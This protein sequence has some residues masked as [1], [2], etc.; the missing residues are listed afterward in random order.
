MTKIQDVNATI[1]TLDDSEIDFVAGGV[2]EGGCI[3]LPFPIKL[4]E[5]LVPQKPG[6]RWNSGIP[7]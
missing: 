5:T 6:P 4:P 3:V 2:V 1:R 7:L